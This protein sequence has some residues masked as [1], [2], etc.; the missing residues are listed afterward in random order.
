[1][2]DSPPRYE[3]RIWDDNLE[4]LKRRLAALSIR[5]RTLESTELYLVSRATDRC[6]A[7]IRAGLLDV[8]RLTGERRG[9]QQWT[10]IL[11]A[12]FPIDAQALSACMA[13]LGAP[14]EPGARA[15]SE[16]ELRNE[17]AASRLIVPLPLS[18]R[19]EIFRFDGCLAE[20]AEVTLPSLAGAVRHTVALESAD[21]ERVL[22]LATRLDIHGYSNRSYVQELR[23]LIHLANS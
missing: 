17:L 10:P 11:K 22:D 18:K 23:R 9:L 20:F 19:R 14:L 1:M 16:S 8:K 7:K 13:C 15:R 2:P 4:S 12:P 3:F 21:D 6:N 5:D